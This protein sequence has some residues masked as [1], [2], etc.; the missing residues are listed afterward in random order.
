MPFYAK[1]GN[2]PSKRHTTFE[3]SAGGYYYEQ[4]FGT[5]GFH[6]FSS[7]LYHVHRPTQV[8]SVSAPVDLTPVAAINKNISSQMLRGFEVA[9]KDDFLESRTILLFNNDLNI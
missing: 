9:P 6:G 4:L 2:F 3:K 5:E 8:R 1:L 7:L